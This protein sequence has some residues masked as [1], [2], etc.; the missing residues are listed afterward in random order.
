MNDRVFRIHIEAPPE[1]VWKE[2]TKTD[3]AQGAV[4]NAWL[5]TT[6][7][8]EGAPLQMRTGTGKNVIVDGHVLV[9]RPFT[10]FAHTHRF[11]QYEDP[12]CEVHYLLVEK[13]G[14]TEVTMRIK[15]CPE[16]TRTAKDMA[17]G[18]DFILKNLKQLAEGRGLPFGTRVHVRADGFDGVRA[19]QALPVPPTGRCSNRRSPWLTRTPPSSRSSTTSRP[20]PARRLPSCTPRWP[21]AA[22]PSMARSAAG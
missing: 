9:H 10:H 8:G 16:G 12:V 18:G 5:A 4:Y 2:I 11:T 20:R 19:A 22:P 15:G 7:L 17:A 21:P 3:E 14:G 1:R 13:D 6:V